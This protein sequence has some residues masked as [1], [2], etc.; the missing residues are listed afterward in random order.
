MS[1]LQ[2]FVGVGSSGEGQIRAAYMLK[3]EKL[4]APAEGKQWQVVESFNAGDEI[5][6]DAGSKDVFKAAIRDGYAIVS[7]ARD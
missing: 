4:P 5:L 1:C 3:S 6:K 2:K 7:L